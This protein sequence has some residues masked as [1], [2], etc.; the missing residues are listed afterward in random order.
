MQTLL[1]VIRGRGL[2]TRFQPIVAL[3]SGTVVAYE[4]L[5][6]GPEGS[7][8]KAPDALFAAARDQHVL[9]ELDEA[10]RDTALTSA[11]RRV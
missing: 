10:C 9:T 1:E 6:R 8:W 3:D 5:T 7:V 4:A 2:S 11:R